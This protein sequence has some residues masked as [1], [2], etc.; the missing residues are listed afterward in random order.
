M[1]P[2]ADL[3]VSTP[4]SKGMRPV[5]KGNQLRQQAV[6]SFDDN[7]SKGHQSQQLDASFKSSMH[8]H[9]S[10]LFA[11][12]DFPEH[13]V[14]ALKELREVFSTLP[15][16]LVENSL[17]EAGYDANEASESCL[18]LLSIENGNVSG[19]W[20]DSGSP[21]DADTNSIATDTQLEAPSP[22][23]QRGV[24]SEWLD[25]SEKMQVCYLNK[26]RAA[27]SCCICFTQEL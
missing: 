13:A 19:A 6:A 2:R 22:M 20:S 14:R 24:L 8:D 26:C 3:K 23:H 11:G 27:F 10:Q 15:P 18:K 5:R 25:P 1:S 4:A 7:T 17:R 12:E 9:D 21:S 16:N